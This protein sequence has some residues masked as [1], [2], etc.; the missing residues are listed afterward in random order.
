MDG[1]LKNFEEL[2][3]LMP[4]GWEQ[5]ARELG[6]LTRSREIKNAKDLFPWG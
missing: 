3:K 1:E 5:K 6:A 2:L 4:E